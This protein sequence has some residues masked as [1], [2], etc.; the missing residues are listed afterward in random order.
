MYKLIGFAN[1]AL[2]F[3]THYMDRIALHI[4][5]LLS[6]NGQVPVP[7]IGMFVR[8]RLCASLKDEQKR[9][10]PP[11][12]ETVL[13]SRSELESVGFSSALVV[14]YARKYRV[15]SSEAVS[16][17]NKDLEELI[18]ILTQV[19][20][21]EITGVGVLYKDEAGEIRLMPLSSSLSYSEKIGYPEIPLLIHTE[22]ITGEKTETTDE[23]GKSIDFDTDKYWYIPVHKRW[24]KSV[25]AVAL[26]VV[27]ALSVILKS[28]H[29]DRRIIDQASVIPVEHIIKDV[30]GQV[31]DKETDVREQ[32]SC[33]E[34]AEEIDKGKFHLIVATFAAESDARKFVEAQ[35]VRA[36][37]LDVIVTKTRSRVSASSSND[38]SALQ[39]QLLDPAFR[40]LYPQAWIWENE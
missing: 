8:R 38:R 27:M 30:V 4:Q 9:I 20:E 40:N 33:D 7:G 35:G 25:A 28:D 11:G 13:D 24:A 17:L 39:H 37:E 34:M 16:L 5:Y 14:S 31:K 3:S 18:K 15:G 29:K 26:L 36:G 1:F 12:W 6:R 32:V 21:V 23:T 2:R 22:E 19:G 10:L